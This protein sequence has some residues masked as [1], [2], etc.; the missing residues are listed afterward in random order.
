[1]GLPL[2]GNQVRESV[3]LPQMGHRGRLRRHYL[4]RHGHGARM[5]RLHEGTASTR[6]RDL[7]GANRFIFQGW[8]WWQRKEAVAL[9]GRLGFS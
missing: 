5:L 4:V 1:M 8:D 6:S 9:G 7:L 2:P 3:R